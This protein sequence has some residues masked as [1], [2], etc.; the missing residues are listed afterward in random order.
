MQPF[1]SFTLH[2]LLGPV[3]AV[4]T[5]FVNKFVYHLYS[6]RKISPSCIFQL[7]LR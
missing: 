6:I 5:H 3:T 2:A 4:D 7:T 1:E